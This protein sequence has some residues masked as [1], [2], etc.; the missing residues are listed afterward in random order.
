MIVKKSRPKSDYQQ[1]ENTF[2]FS[3]TIFTRNKNKLEQGKTEPKILY[4]FKHF[5]K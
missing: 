2:L 3:M 5:S 4:F 1:I